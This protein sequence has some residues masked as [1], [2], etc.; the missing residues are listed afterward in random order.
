MSKR[1]RFRHL[2]IAAA[3]DGTLPG[4]FT[5]QQAAKIASLT[6]KQASDCMSHLRREG[7]VEIAGGTH[8]HYLYTLVKTPVKPVV[9]TEDDPLEILLAAMEKAEPIIRR[10]IKV[11][12]AFEE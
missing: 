1:R 7:I 5:Y 9:T 3:K 12:K 11:N 2:I 10:M 4:C 8:G 6:N